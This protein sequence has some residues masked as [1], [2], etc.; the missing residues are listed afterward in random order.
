MCQFL[1]GDST[2]NATFLKTN[3]ASKHSVKLNDI[4]RY[5][6]IWN[7]EWNKEGMDLLSFELQNCLKNGN[8]RPESLISDAISSLNDRSK[9]EQWPPHLDINKLD[10]KKPN[11]IW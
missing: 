5:S 6:S 3:K 1:I 9:L 11:W 2:I 7:I 8:R 4:S 10:S